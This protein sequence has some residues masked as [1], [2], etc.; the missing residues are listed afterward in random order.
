MGRV[1][2]ETFIKNYCVRSQCSV[3]GAQR[4][5]AVISE[6]TCRQKVSHVE[7]RART[8]IKPRHLDPAYDLRHN[9]LYTFVTWTNVE[10]TKKKSCKWQSRYQ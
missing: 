1:I 3:A 8:I 2:A 6:Y 5:C 4:K 9:I 7:L 10:V